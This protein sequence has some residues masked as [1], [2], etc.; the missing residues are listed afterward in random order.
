MKVGSKLRGGG[1]LLV[2][3]WDRAFKFDHF[4]KETKSFVQKYLYI[5]EKN[6]SKKNN[7]GLKI[8]RKLGVMTAQK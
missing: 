4:L 8:H 6:N 2:V 7:Q 5:F 1:G 3:S